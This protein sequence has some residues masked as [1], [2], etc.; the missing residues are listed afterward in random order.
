[1]D[2]LLGQAGS[3]ASLPVL[4][5]FFASSRDRHDERLSF[6]TTIRGIAARPNLARSWSLHPVTWQ[7]DGGPVTEDVTLQD[8][9]FRNAGFDEADV[10]VFAIG[11]RVGPGTRAEYERAAALRR[12]HGSRPA[13]LM[14][15]LAEAD[16]V[17]LAGGPDVAQ[18]HEQVIADALCVPTNYRGIDEFKEKLTEQLEALLVGTDQFAAGVARA[19]HRGFRRATLALGGVGLV[20]LLCT[21]T[22]GF[23]DNGVDVWK[24]TAVLV[25]PPVLFLLGLWAT[26]E[27]RRLLRSFR[28]AWR[29][30][31]CSD[32]QLLDDFAGVIPAIAW[33]RTAAA[34]ER[35]HAMALTNTIVVL[36]AAFVLPVVVHK[37]CLLDEFVRW[38]FVV[39]ADELAHDGAPRSLC[40]HNVPVKSRWVE[41]G[42]LRFP[43]TLRDPEVVARRQQDDEMI[44]VYAEGRLGDGTKFGTDSAFREN[45]GPQVALPLQ[46]LGYLGLWGVQ[47][48][49]AAF[50]FGSLAALRRSLK[51]GGLGRRVARGW[52]GL[53]A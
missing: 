53:S 24:V 15:V 18:F 50:A 8:A 37:V 41:R 40:D 30:V 34:A 48:G 26:W 5:V 22:M 47:S 52:G 17:T 4:R 46:P 2:Q 16:G 10:I 11:S 43:Y 44:F 29:S 20:T 32:A 36:L 14:Y 49:F 13:V 39:A 23:P 27:Y 21:Q 33:P 31:K 45:M 7:T 35:Q 28:S 25:A 51:A 1:M 9:I 19:A 6:E 12:R 42:P 3:A 38:D